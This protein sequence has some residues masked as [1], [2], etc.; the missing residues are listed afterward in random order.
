MS[1]ARGTRGAGV[2]PDAARRQRI[3]AYGIARDDRG[4]VRAAAHLSV[5]GRWF[6]PGG[7]VEH[8]E[9][10]ADSLRREVAEE[11]GLEVSA[12]TLLGVVADTGPIPDGTVL[13]TV[14]LLYRID[15]WQGALRDEHGGSSDHAEWFTPAEIAGL[16]LVRY[17]RDALGRFGADVG[18]TLEPRRP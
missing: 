14:R 6:L 17:V 2:G 16:H 18:I 10:P 4:R 15:G 1:D 12:T 7:G 9:T 11:T 13:H 3:G 5:A 8:G